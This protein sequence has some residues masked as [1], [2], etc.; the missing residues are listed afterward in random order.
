MEL[1]WALTVRDA[2]YGSFSLVNSEYRY[3]MIN[4]LAFTQLP[5]TVFE[6]FENQVLVPLGFVLDD[7]GSRVTNFTC[8]ELEE[9]ME[10]LIF[11]FDK[12]VFYLPPVSYL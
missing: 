8:A 7:Q 12:Y 5:R 11:V 6:S 10:P 9:K 2:V 1:G 3:A 4:N